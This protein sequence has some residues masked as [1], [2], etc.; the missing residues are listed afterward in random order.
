MMSKAD[1]ETAVQG[2]YLE[3]WRQSPED[4]KTQLKVFTRGSSK[5]DV[6]C[7]RVSVSFKVVEL[8]ALS[9]LSLVKYSLTIKFLPIRIQEEIMYAL[10]RNVGFLLFPLFFPPAGIWK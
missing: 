10:K 5:Q 1:K 3:T 9:S 8:G 2:Y 6:R 7:G 4:P